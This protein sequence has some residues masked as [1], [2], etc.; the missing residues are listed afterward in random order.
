MSLKRYEKCG[1]L[2]REW[3][4][5]LDIQQQH[6]VACEIGLSLALLES[7]LPAEMENRC[8]ARSTLSQT[9]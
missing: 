9:K 2:N 3:H 8:V 7:K 5:Y 1:E 4:R 6:Y